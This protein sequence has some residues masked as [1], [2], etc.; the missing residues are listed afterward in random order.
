MRLI[1]FLL[2]NDPN[3]QDEHYPDRTPE[4]EKEHQHL[5][6]EY[7]KYREQK[8]AAKLKA[9]IDNVRV[10]K[11]T[12]SR[13][14][15]PAGAEKVTILGRPCII[16]TPDPKERADIKRLIAQHERFI[17]ARSQDAS[18]PKSVA[19]IAR[20][21]GGRTP[22]MDAV[23]LSSLTNYIKGKQK[24]RSTAQGKQ[25]ADKTLSHVRSY[26][27]KAVHAPWPELEQYVFKYF[28][29][30]EEYWKSAYHKKDWPKYESFLL[31]QIAAKSDNVYPFALRY[32]AKVKPKGWPE[33]KAA[34]ESVLYTFTSPNVTSAYLKYCTDHSAS[35]N[36]SLKQTLE[37][38]C[39][40]DAMLRYAV[41]MRKL[42]PVAEQKAEERYRKLSHPYTTD[43]EK[44]YATMFLRGKWPA[45]GL[46]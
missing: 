35:I 8:V 21:L 24:T 11:S 34:M 6:Q 17:K 44:A 23:I 43:A 39:S 2:E 27:E 46:V 29:M 32:A 37:Q 25:H 33:F 41:K 19:S 4:E 15:I 38:K 36:L 28:T 26:I 18:S 31:R 5:M 16:V 1:H 42:W 30:A 7:A 9:Y 20:Q 14:T 10:L 3:D 45:V 13:K 40:S 22:E 12:P